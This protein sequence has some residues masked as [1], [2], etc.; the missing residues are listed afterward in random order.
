MPPGNRDR[1][2]PVTRQRVFVLRREPCPKL[3]QDFD[4]RIL[5]RVAQQV[6]TAVGNRRPDMAR[7][8]PVTGRSVRTYDRVVDP[9]LHRPRPFCRRSIPSQRCAAVRPPAAG[10]CALSRGTSRVVPARGGSQ[11][12]RAG[13]PRA[14]QDARQRPRRKRPYF[15]AALRRADVSRRLRK[16]PARCAGK[17][18]AGRGRPQAGERPRC[19]GRRGR[20]GGFSRQLVV[21]GDR[22]RDGPRRP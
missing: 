3:L 13:R 11:T 19:A 20:M 14:S 9:A 22:W 8:L 7:A 10:G 4:E 1:R 2:S 5:T 6:T 15:P 12:A 18:A 16:R 21:I 17:V